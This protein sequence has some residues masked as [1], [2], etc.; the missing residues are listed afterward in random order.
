MKKNIV[1]FIVL[2]GL[3][4]SCATSDPNSNKNLKSKPG[5]LSSSPSP[6]AINGTKIAHSSKMEVKKNFKL[7][8]EVGAKWDRSDLWWHKI[9]PVNGKFDFA[10]S[11]YIVSEFEKHGVSLLPILDYGAAWFDNCAGPITEKERKEFANYVYKVVK[12]YPQITYWEVWNEPNLKMFWKH[13]PNA[14]LYAEL[15]K[16]T[17][18]AARK[19]NPNVK[20]VGG[21]LAGAQ[22]DYIEDMYLA[23][24]KDYFDVFSY[25]YYRANMPDE[26]VETEILKVKAMM[27]RFGDGEKPVWISEMGVSS[28]PK[29]G[30]DYNTQA[31]YLVRNYIVALSFPWIEKIFQF[32]M[33]N[34]GD[35]IEGPWDGHLGLI[36]ASRKKKPS[37]YAYSNMVERLTLSNGEPCKLKKIKLGNAKIKTY[38][39][40]KEENLC[41]VA[42]ADE[43]KSISILP[44]KNGLK[45]YDNSGKIVRS[46]KPDKNKKVSIKLSKTPVYITGISPS[47]K[48][49]ACASFPDGAVPVTPGER[50]S[51]KFNLQNP[52]QTGI[53]ANLKWRIK[54]DNSDSKAKIELSGPKKI[55]I[56]PLESKTVRATL[57]TLETASADD[58]VFSVCEVD[59]GGMKT[60]ASCLTPVFQSVKLRVNMLT[61]D[62]GTFF[63]TTATQIGEIPQGGS[64]VL[65]SNHKNLETNLTE[66]LDFSSNKIISWKTYIDDEV[67]KNL[68]EPVIITAKWQKGKKIVL[69]KPMRVAFHTFDGKTPKLDGNLQEWAD[70]PNMKLISPSQMLKNDNHFSTDDGGGYV[71]CHWSKEGLYFALTILDNKWPVNDFPE[72]ELWKG[73]AIEFY[74]GLTSP[75]EH[76]RYDANDAQIGIG[77][78]QD[79]DKPITWNWKS[80]TNL[81]NVKL[82]YGKSDSK[83]KIVEGFIPA[84]NFPASIPKKGDLI[85][86]DVSLKDY[87]SEKEYSSIIWHGDGRNWLDPSN[88]G[89]AIVK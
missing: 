8:K 64:V 47:Y 59:A 49:N 37:F 35:E 88:W 33:I 82:A 27:S 20:L 39:Y 2:L 57:S 81:F 67:L 13:T 75:Y 68:S 85:S 78:R 84:E 56:P 89:V 51:L 44:G 54:T 7:L 62:K 3:I 24:A 10:F 41:L 66:K 30:V 76:I 25:H 80:K 9:E 12:R 5:I 42:W 69:S 48:W 58:S 18:E 17:A 40:E 28:H 61:N 22:W 83:E 6:F 79:S 36:E 11:D 60:E 34:W 77:F 1:I 53:T 26:E 45:I 16:T 15:L 38:Y 19:A 31:A 86:F 73:D 71:Q 72:V 43:N 63:K 74:V 46:P 29:H 14:K 87:D 50:V 32:D 4:N 21:V 55:F 70:I 23:K 52:Y 65:F